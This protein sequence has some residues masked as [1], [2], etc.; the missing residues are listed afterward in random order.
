MVGISAATRSPSFPLRSRNTLNC[1]SANAPSSQRYTGFDMELD[2]S[3]RLRVAIDKI[4]SVG[5]EYGDAKALSWLLQEQ[6]KVVLASE[7]AK[8]DGGSYAEKERQALCSEA[9]KVHLEGTKEAIA[10]EHRLKASYERWSYEFEALRSLLSLE[11]KKIE[12]L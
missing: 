12:L 8:I 3:K 2:F 6:R 10:D 7:I 9:Y 4:E 1:S 5:S 11:K